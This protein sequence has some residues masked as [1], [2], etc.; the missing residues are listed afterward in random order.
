MTGLCPQRPD[1][2][3][4]YPAAGM[5]VTEASRRRGGGRVTNQQ[6]SNALGVTASP[7]IVTFCPWPGDPSSTR[8]R[9]PR[10]QAGTWCGT[11]T[12]SVTISPRLRREPLRE[13]D[14]PPLLPANIAACSVLLGNNLAR[15]SLFTLVGCS[16]LTRSGEARISL[17]LADFK[18]PCLC[19]L[20]F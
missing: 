2:T 1:A 7:A 14:L 17:L 20:T 4:R 10:S 12:A 13:I 18:F 19:A 5:Q 6:R 8:L 15:H 11:C 9:R 16:V 3:D